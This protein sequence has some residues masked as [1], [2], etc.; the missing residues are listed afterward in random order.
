MIYDERDFILLKTLRK[1]SRDS[2]G[3]RT[4]NSLGLDCNT[5][6]PLLFIVQGVNKILWN[7]SWNLYFISYNTHHIV[8]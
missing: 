2:L 5:F 4:L 1:D 8:A 6:E 7:I 3:F